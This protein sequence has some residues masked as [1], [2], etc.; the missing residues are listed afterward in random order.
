MDPT[1]RQVAA[2]AGLAFVPVAIYGVVS[3]EL[4]LVTGP[5]TVL[6][7]GLIVG[8]LLLLF[9]PDTNEHAAGH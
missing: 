6:S 9:A 2:L 7:L 5:L 8:M 3:G 4:T 1:P